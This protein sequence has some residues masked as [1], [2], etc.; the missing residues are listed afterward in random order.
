[1]RFAYLCMILLF[2]IPVAKAQE[3]EFE[4]TGTCIEYEVKV[5]ANVSK[6][7]DVKIDLKAPE[8][9]EVYDPKEGWK[10]ANYYIINGLCEPEKTFRVRVNTRKDF[11]LGV[12][13]RRGSKVLKSEYVEVKQSCP[14]LE[15]SIFFLVSL[16]IIL[17]LLIGLALYVK[18]K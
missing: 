14:E 18:S 3:I 7:Y 10:S 1:M 6:C 12:N 9:G 16:I 15:L 11:L 4:V 13:L 5:K 17:I 8:G 2:L